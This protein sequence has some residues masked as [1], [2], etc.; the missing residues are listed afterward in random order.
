MP[1]LIIRTFLLSL[2]FGGFFA[3]QTAPPATPPIEP[4]SLSDPADQYRELFEAV[5]LAG[6]FPDSKT[7]ADCTPLLSEEEILAQFA[8]QKDQQEFD[9]QS[10]VNAH[11][12]PPHAYASGFEAD[13]SRSVSEHIESLWPIL[14][15]KP[16]T[17]TSGTLIPLPN[18]YVVPGGRFGE[19]YYW[20]SYFTMLG[21]QVSPTAQ[22]MIRPMIDN[23]AFLIDTVG[24]IPNGNRTYYLGRSQPPFFSLMV[25]LLSEVEGKQVLGEYYASM[26]N[27]YAFWMAGAD[28]LSEGR[29]AFRRVVL[30]SGGE[31]LNRHWDDFPRPRSESYR[32]DVELQQDTRRTSEDLFPNL[33]AGC[34][35]G[36][37]FSSRWFRDGMNRGTIRTAELIPVDL[38]SLLYHL[39]LTLAEAAEVSGD[40]AAHAGYQDAAQARKTALNAYCWDAQQQMFSDYDFV[41]ADRTKIP[42][43]AMMYPLFFRMA[44]EAQAR[45]TA[46][47]IATDFLQPGGVVTTLSQTGEQWDAPNGWAPLQWMTIQGLRNYGDD[48]IANQIKERWTKLNIKVYRNTGKLVEKYNVM[49]LS[50]DAGGGEY[51]L[52]DGF[53]WTNG[54]L[55]KLLSE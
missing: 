14:T 44:D 33:R 20:D 30:L 28:S 8:A 21:L 47:I 17:Q 11:F 5:Q 26:Q 6:L 48:E 43:L 22:S 55:L 31:L 1:S 45:A 40:V 18:P 7:F 46:S 25:R 34:E 29:P 15:R 19:V 27:E 4:Q 16:D 35:S 49:D 54:V 2:L 10:F 51:V 23:F 12:K 24:F 53:G 37:D 39:E 36:W 3:C 13:K 50:L 9:L 38:N 42:T 32:E 41:N 52:Q